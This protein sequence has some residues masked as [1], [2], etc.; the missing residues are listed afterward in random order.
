MFC[1][2]FGLVLV[3]VGLGGLGGLVGLSVMARS[4]TEV[5]CEISSSSL[6]IVADELSNFSVSVGS[7]PAETS[8]IS[9]FEY[10]T[11]F[12]VRVATAHH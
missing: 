4:T 6:A 8:Y 12:G 1:S 7:V 11:D 5:I 10:S 3:L 2:S 9:G